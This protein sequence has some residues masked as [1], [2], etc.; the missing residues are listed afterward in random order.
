MTVV[1]RVSSVKF[2]MSLLRYSSFQK[3]DKLPTSEETGI[4]DNVTK[5]ANQRS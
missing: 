1:T 5:E 2:E 4:G 3:S